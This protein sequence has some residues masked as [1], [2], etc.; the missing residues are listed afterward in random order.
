MRSNVLYAFY[1]FQVTPCTYDCVHF[2]SL[3]LE[4]AKQKDSSDIRVIFVPEERDNLLGTVPAYYDQS[5]KDWRFRQI[6]LPAVLSLVP[7]CEVIVCKSRESAQDE[8]DRLDGANI[9]PPGYSV[10][11]PLPRYFHGLFVGSQPTAFHRLQA[12][13][14]A[15]EHIDR[16]KAEHA[17]AGELIT[18]TLRQCDYCLD[19]NSNL[20]AWGALARELAQSGYQVAIIPDTSKA[21]TESELRAHFEHP[22]VEIF[23]TASFH[24]ELRH[25]LYE[26]S[27]LNLITNNGPASLLY[28][29]KRAKFL[30]FKVI[31]NGPHAANLQE[32]AA[33]ARFRPGRHWPQSQANQ[34]FIWEDDRLPTLKRSFATYL[35]HIQADPTLNAEELVSKALQALQDGDIESAWDWSAIAVA[36][37]NKDEK[38]WIA[39]VCIL[40]DTK[41]E[42]EA[43][44]QAEEAMTRFENPFF[45]EKR[46]ACARFIESGYELH[47]LI[48]ETLTLHPQ[49]IASLNKL[50]K[51]AP[52]RYSFAQAGSQQGIYVFGASAGG[53]KALE[54]L[55]KQG[56]QVLGFLDNDPNK[57]NQQIQGL[58]VLPIDQIP[59][60]SFSRIQIAS[61]HSKAILLQL[62]ECGIPIEKI[63][64]TPAEI[65]TST[66]SS[67]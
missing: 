54:A 41:R 26:S 56:Q 42:Q 10:A 3:L 47:R 21:L 15:L 34:L 65:L 57:H 12:S 63:E 50:L 2:I 61:Q 4:A 25:A 24:F 27:F 44:Y 7:N 29:S 30:Y 48:R 52:A 53:R 28:L 35:R 1:D 45:S 62:L 22:K 31:S 8:I 60:R 23:D 16:W 11:K 51:L 19:R 38:A 6:V 58:T 20:Q 46:L 13:P 43:F 59:G 32:M 14:R 40:I 49:L 5:D 36:I 37:F 33:K 67:S 55:Q 64:I 18:I 9:Y 17:Q 66:Q 39:R